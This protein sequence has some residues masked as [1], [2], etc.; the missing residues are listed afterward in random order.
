MIVIN[1]VDIVVHGVKGYVGETLSQEMNAQ[2][3]CL[4]PRC[5]PTARMIG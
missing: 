5:V 1:Q 2:G 3:I 4:V